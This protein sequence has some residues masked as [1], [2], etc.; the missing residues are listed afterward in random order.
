M[1]DAF[2]DE[3]SIVAERDER[4]VF[5]T[6]DHGAQSLDAF[7]AKFPDRFY[8]IGIAEQNMVSMAGGLA[9]KGKIPVVYG[10]APFVSLRALEQVT[11]DVASMNLP[12]TIVGIGP[13][14][15]Y[16]TDG[17]THH[18]LQD[19]GAM[20]TVPNLTILNSSDP[21]STRLFAS[22]TGSEM[23]PRYI[24]I[25]KGQLQSLERVEKGWQ[26][27]G[28]G[29]VKQGS[30]KVVVITTGSITHEVLRA[31]EDIEA[32]LELAP[33]V[34]DVH[35]LKPLPVAELA[36]LISE[37]D[38]I[39]VVEEN[40]V[41]LAKEIAFELSLR[42]QAAK[43]SSLAVKEKFFSEGAT[44]DFMREIGGVSSKMIADWI[45]EQRQT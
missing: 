23:A 4:I 28:F 35:R 8:N 3:L 9:S 33:T 36:D 16:S 1:R 30:K 25:E 2:F 17:Y 18:G 22:E 11:L 12:V 24:R 5:F 38:E 31:C 34:L 29:T 21:V 14:F 45:V 6:A 13:G 20:A 39:F 42:G 27:K 15:C 32:E 43:I 40:Y 10:I 19:L 44:R 41:F 7:Q 26:A 37:A